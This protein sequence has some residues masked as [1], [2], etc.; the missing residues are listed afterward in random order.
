MNFCTVFNTLLR[1]QTE[2]CL[3]LLVCCCM[4]FY[5]DMS[6]IIQVK[7]TQLGGRGLMFQPTWICNIGLSSSDVVFWFIRSIQHS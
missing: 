3:Y 2:R 5:E 4:C 1:F 7:R 6:Q